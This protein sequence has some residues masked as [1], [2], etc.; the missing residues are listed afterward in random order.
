MQLSSQTR[1]RLRRQAKARRAEQ[2]ANIVSRASMLTL[3]LGL[4]G[5]IIIYG[6]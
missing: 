6:G 1:D 2:V 4:W 3:A 5:S